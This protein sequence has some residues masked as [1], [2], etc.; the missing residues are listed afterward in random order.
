M[1]LTGV[2][3][4]GGKSRRLGRNKLVEPFQGGPLIARVIERLRPVCGEIVVVGAP[5]RRSGRL[6][7]SQRRAHRLRPL[8][9]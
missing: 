6:A 2:V 5:G 9:R 1:P 8:P 7:P 3:L 4:A